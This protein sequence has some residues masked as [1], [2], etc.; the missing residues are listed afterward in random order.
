[1][2]TNQVSKP[3][4]R[5]FYIKVSTRSGYAH[6][7]CLVKSHSMASL[8]SME[9]YSHLLRLISSG[10]FVEQR[11]LRRLISRE[12]ESLEIPGLSRVSRERVDRGIEAALEM[13][14]LPGRENVFPNF[15]FHMQDSIGQLRDR[16]FDIGSLRAGNRGNCQDGRTPSTE[17]FRSMIDDQIT[18]YSFHDYI[19]TNQ[20]LSEALQTTKT[21]LKDAAIRL[22]QCLRSVQQIDH[23]LRE[24]IRFIVSVLAAIAVLAISMYTL[25]V[26]STKSRSTCKEEVLPVPRKKPL[27]LELVLI[28]SPKQKGD[29]IIEAI[30]QGL[31]KGKLQKFNIPKEETVD[32]ILRRYFFA[33]ND[34]EQTVDPTDRS[35]EEEVLARVFP[36]KL[37]PFND[38]LFKEYGKSY[39]ETVEDEQSKH[40]KHLGV[41]ESDDKMTSD[42]IDSKIT[43]EVWGKKSKEQSQ[44]LIDKLHS[45]SISFI[46][47]LL[48]KRWDVSAEKGRKALF[49][50]VEVAV[51]LLTA[52]VVVHQF[53]MQEV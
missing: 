31:I 20:P 43:K 10:I 7:Y 5:L 42:A 51:S 9:E 46:E 18:C 35:N 11:L 21:V 47:S 39:D 36:T 28:C 19:E 16:L 22:L 24:N 2:V 12:L 15:P 34:S 44:E 40:L 41:Q 1:M 45:L 14:Y 38:E 13:C 49:G 26:S 8:V 25:E 50:H 53:S 32:Y 6:F 52:F 29:D 27:G 3:L 37:T 4:P 33:V 48:V 30:L 17:Q 23:D